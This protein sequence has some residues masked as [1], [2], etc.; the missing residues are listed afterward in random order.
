[1]G[2]FVVS[3]TNPFGC[4][5]NGGREKEKKKKGGFD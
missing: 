4:S 1:V 2:W 3:L 5:E